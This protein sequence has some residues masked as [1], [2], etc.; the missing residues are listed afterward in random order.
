MG[1]MKKN[2]L[3]IVAIFMAVFLCASASEARHFKVYGYKTPHAGE[4]ELVYWTDYV[5]QSDLTMGYFE[6]TV[7][8]EK[9]LGHTIEVEYGVTD[10]WTIAGYLDF[11]QPSG[12]DFKY[13][14][15]RAVVS[16]Y[17]FFEKGQR[18]F[19]GAIY[20]EYYLPET[21]YPEKSTGAG[22]PKEK[23]EARIILEKDFGSTTLT[24][25]P[26]F[27]KVVSGGH[28]EE[29]L[30]FEYGAS[31]YYKM[32]PK[33]KPGLEIYGGMGELVDFKPYDKQKHYI[34]PAAKWKLSDHL[35]WNIGVAFG[36]TNASD[37]IVVKSILEWEL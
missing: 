31:L 23:I 21:R 10:R 34:V 13:I 27:E 4:I 30:E 24:L 2:I 36:L 17:R 18:F 8:R 32:T 16:R 35:K 20:I 12:E 11:E 25:N 22:E 29:G 28:V 3:F 15:S 9:L 33:L 7:E 6:K 26:K 14:Q 19:D 1:F 37:D 5:V